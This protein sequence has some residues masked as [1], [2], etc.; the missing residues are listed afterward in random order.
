VAAG[1]PALDVY[2]TAARRLGVDAANAAAV[3]DSTNGLRAAAAAGML[4]IASPN[5]D[6]AR[7]RIPRRFDAGRN[8]EERKLSVARG[9]HGVCLAAAS[10][11]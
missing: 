3:E 7:R 4:V 8:R 9:I 6:R 1:K 10:F 5:R 11:D 2:L